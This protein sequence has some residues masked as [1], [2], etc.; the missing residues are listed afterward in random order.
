MC[1]WLFQIFLYTNGDSYDK[2]HKTVLE[3]TMYDPKA[4]YSR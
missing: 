2:I 1:Q 3:V 4:L